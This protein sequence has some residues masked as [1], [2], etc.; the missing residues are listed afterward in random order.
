MK[1]QPFTERQQILPHP[2][3]RRGGKSPPFRGAAVAGLACALALYAASAS[4]PARAD[5]PAPITE[6][7]SITSLGLDPMMSLDPSA[8][9]VGALPG[10]VTPA[11][12]RKPQRE[13]EWRFDFHGFLTAPLVVGFN[14]RPM[15]LPVQEKT[16]LHAPPVVPDDLETFSHT[17]V[18]PTTYARLAFS[19]GNGFVTANASIVARQATVSTAFLEPSAQQGITD[20]FVAI[21]PA[22]YRNV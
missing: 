15:P 7:D 6:D 14:T 8:P 22:P 3:D 2:G 11:F 4:A 19:E 21:T 1:R 20:L 9:Q 10:G 17:G 12:G 13:D 16:V 5:E 18:V